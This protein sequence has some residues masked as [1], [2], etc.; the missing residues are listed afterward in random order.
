M[1]KNF[2]VGPRREAGDTG[3]RKRRKTSNL[4]TP[5]PQTHN[6]KPVT[7]VAAMFHL[8]VARVILGLID[9]LTSHGGPP[10]RRSILSS[11]RGFA[12]ATSL[13]KLGQLEPFGA[14]DGLPIPWVECR[15][16]DLFEEGFVELAP[17]DDT[18][19]KVFRLVVSD[20]GRRLL[21]EQ[22]L[23][24][25]L[26]IFGRANRSPRRLSRAEEELQAAV[27]AG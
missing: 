1:S 18:R 12:P 27:E 11:L 6:K 20:S 13:E 22:D 16:D 2:R 7:G 10:E 24:A 26:K 15:L 3:R 9:D 19:T 14:F 17:P 4:K 25:A 23:A 21:G 8:A 5:Q